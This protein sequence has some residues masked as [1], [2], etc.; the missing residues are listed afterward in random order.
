MTLGSRNWNTLPELLAL[1]NLSH[2][3][4]KRMFHLTLSG[5]G[6]ERKKNIKTQEERW[7]SDVRCFFLSP[8]PKS[9][10]HIH[11]HAKKARNWLN[12]TS[13]DWWECPWPTGLIDLSVLKRWRDLE[14]MMRFKTNW[15]NRIAAVRLHVNQLFKNIC[16]R[17]GCVCSDITG[18]EGV[19]SDLDLWP[20]TSN[21]FI[22]KSP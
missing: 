16:P 8:N 12:P 4:K 15:Y 3:T 21:Q 5:Y 6:G 7:C 1:F 14:R 10:S 13:M 20:P 22:L 17:R 9:L 19:H 11:T 2:L 18:I